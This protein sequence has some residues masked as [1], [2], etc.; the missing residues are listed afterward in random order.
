MNFFCFGKI[1]FLVYFSLKIPKKFFNLYIRFLSKGFFQLIQGVNVEH[2]A[3]K[4]SVCSIF[5]VQHPISVGS[6][7]P[8]NCPTKTNSAAGSLF[9]AD[10]FNVGHLTFTP[11]RQFLRL[12]FMGAVPWSRLTYPGLEWFCQRFRSFYGCYSS[13]RHSP[14][15]H[16]PSGCGPDVRVARYGAASGAG[17]MICCWTVHAVE[18]SSW[19]VAGIARNEADHNTPVKHSKNL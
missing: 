14:Q 19:A 1:A 18:A 3:V 7:A 17:R 11:C 5:G 6:W 15:S 12:A 8:K 4:W 10:Q 13:V 2:L 16:S 9:R